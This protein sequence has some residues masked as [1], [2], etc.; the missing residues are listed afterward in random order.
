MSKND[1]DI[2]EFLASFKCLPLQSKHYVDNFDELLFEIRHDV[3]YS[4]KVQ[5]VWRSI[6][7]SR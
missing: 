5:Q 1:K 2:I 3:E 4:E 6:I 7:D